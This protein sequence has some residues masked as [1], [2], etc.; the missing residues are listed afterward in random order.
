MSEDWNYFCKHANVKNNPDEVWGVYK[1]N[2]VISENSR[3][4]FIKTRKTQIMKSTYYL[5]FPVCIYFLKT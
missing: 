3:L 1:N 5:I 2:L 4:Q